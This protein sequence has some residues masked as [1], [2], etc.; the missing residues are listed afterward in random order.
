MGIDYQV[1]QALIAA[2]PRIAGRARGLMLG[3]QRLGVKQGGPQDRHLRRTLRAVGCDHGMEVLRQPDGY[4]ERFFEGLGCGSMQ[5]MDYSDFEGAQITHDLNHPVPQA[6]HGRFD[7]IFD[8]GTIEHVFNVP[9]ALDNVFHML[10]EGGLFISVNGLTGWA[11]HGFYQF[12]PELVWRY[13]QDARGCTVHRCAALSV[14]GGRP[15]REI[16][17]TGAGGARFRGRN[18]PGRWYLYYVAERGADTN[19]AERIAA[20]AQGDYAHKWTRA[21]E[22]KT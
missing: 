12:G 6:L 18:M 1:A 20:A 15:A 21:E 7:F 4:S 16:R 9:Q 22:A 3:R 8:G 13:W 14:D 10:A 2:R 5:V 17:D 11:G 19:P